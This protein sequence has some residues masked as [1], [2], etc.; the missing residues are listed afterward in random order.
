MRARDGEPSPQGC[1]IP[2]R[3]G[4]PFLHDAP[5]YQPSP[6]FPHWTALFVLL[7]HF[8]SHQPHSIQI[9]SQKKPHRRQPGRKGL[10]EEQSV[11]AR[12]GEPSL[13][14]CVIPLRSGR[15][16]LHAAPS[17]RT[18]PALPPR[19]TPTQSR[20]DPAKP[21][22]NANS[23]G[24]PCLKSK[25]CE[26]GMASSVRRDAGSLCDQ[27]GLSCTTHRLTVS[28]PRTCKSAR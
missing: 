4:R 22:T 16:F 14:G 18:V 23:A 15:P 21:R 24:K 5:S 17:C 20:P 2:L 25:V 12:D 9:S 13:Q 10:P 19:H 7:G 8:H 11:R 6:A 28:P 3:S 26:P 1:G 27:A